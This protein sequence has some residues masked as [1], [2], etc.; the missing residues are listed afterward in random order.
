MGKKDEKPLWCICQKFCSKTSWFPG[1]IFKC[2]KFCL[3]KIAQK[4]SKIGQNK[5]IL[6]KS[7][8]SSNFGHMQKFSVI[9]GYAKKISPQGGIEPVTSGVQNQ[10]F[11][12]IRRY[13][14]RF[15]RNSMKNTILIV[16]V[17]FNHFEL[18]LEFKLRFSKSKIA[19]KWSKI[20]RNRKIRSKSCFSSNSG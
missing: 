8:F 2:L 13:G 5:K 17:D 10:K 20:N 3:S 7:C 1:R 19:Q 18:F 11:F 15:N 16:F 6:L 14:T 4:C 12:V 9:F